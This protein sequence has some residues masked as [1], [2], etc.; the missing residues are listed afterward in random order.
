MRLR[1]T[2]ATL[3]LKRVKVSLQKIVPAEIRQ[4]Y[5]LTLANAAAMSPFLS[6]VFH[7]LLSL[8]LS[9][10]TRHHKIARNKQLFKLKS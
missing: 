5:A 9:L 6:A 1:I 7:P 4:L 8:A 10:N 3:S 2:R